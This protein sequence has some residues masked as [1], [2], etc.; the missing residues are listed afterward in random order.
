VR[1]SDVVEGLDA[2]SAALGLSRESLQ[3]AKRAG[4]PGFLPGNRIAVNAVEQWLLKNGDTI[5]EGESLNARR[6]RYLLAQI[7]SERI[8]NE[9]GMKEHWSCAALAEA[10]RRC[11][12]SNARIAAKLMPLD[13]REAY[14]KSIASAF[15]K[16]VGYFERKTSRVSPPPLQVEEPAPGATIADLRA[17]LLGWQIRNREH[18]NAIAN[19]EMVETAEAQEKINLTLAASIAQARRHLDTSAWNGFCTALHAEFAHVLAEPFNP[20]PAK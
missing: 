2:A 18:E 13:I 5:H 12:T 9:T 16:L 11:Q 10:A 4:C 3:L 19:G 14:L 17:A 6:R 7:E 15:K 20:T 8:D 1:K